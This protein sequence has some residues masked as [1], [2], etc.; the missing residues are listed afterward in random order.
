M[1]FFIGE[2]GGKLRH[3]IIYPFHLNEVPNSIG[4]NWVLFL[5]MAHNCDPTF[6]KLWW[7]TFKFKTRA[8]YL[9]SLYPKVEENEDKEE[10]EEEGAGA[11]P[12]HPCCH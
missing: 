8:V 5:I 4:I 10:E 12:H 7:E 11:T 1:N 6:G 3:R 2:L 9:A